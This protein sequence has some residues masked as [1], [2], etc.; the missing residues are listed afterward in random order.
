[1][2]EKQKKHNKTKLILKIVGIV[3]AV[4]GLALAATGIGS[5]FVSDGFP[6]LFCMAILG[7]PKL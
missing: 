5:T 6:E 3:V 7:Q 2:D 4:A 1:M